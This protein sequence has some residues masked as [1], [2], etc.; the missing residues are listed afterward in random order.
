MKR[1]K[2]LTAALGV[3][4]VAAIALTG[5]D[6]VLNEPKKGT[7]TEVTG[8]GITLVDK[9]VL[10]TVIFDP[11]GGD[12]AVIPKGSKGEITKNI[13]YGER[14]PKPSPDP[15][16][17][18]YTFGGWYT[19]TACKS[20]YD[21]DT[22]VKA[23]FTVYAKWEPISYKVI[24]SL[25]GAPGTP[26]DRLGY[27]TYGQTIT[28]PAAPKWTGHIFIGWFKDA[29]G[30]GTAWNFKTDTVTANITLYAKWTLGAVSVDS[31]TEAIADMDKNAT[32]GEM[33]YTLPGG[34]EEPYTDTITLTARETS[35]ASV[36]IDGSDRFITGNGN[37]ITI[38]SGVT[39]TLKNI[40]FTEI[41]FTVAAG[42]KLI[43]GANDGSA[44]D[45]V[46]EENTGTGITVNGGGTLELNTGAMVIGNQASGIVLEDNSVL[47]MTGGTIINNSATSGGCGVRI[48]GGEFTMNGGTIT[49]NTGTGVTVAAGGKLVLDNGAAVQ[50]NTGTG[51]SVSGGTLEMKAGSSVTG[52]GKSGIY[53]EGTG[54]FTMSGGT[55]SGNNARRGGGVQVNGGT[56]TMS[57]GT[58][59][60]NRAVMNGGGVQ[61]TGGTFTM[62]SG[63]ISGNYAPNGGGVF[64]QGGQNMIFNM[65]GGYIKDNQVEWDGSGVFVQANSTFN[66]TGGEITGNVS[67]RPEYN[68]AGAV[69]LDG[70]TLTGNPRIGNPV[71]SGSGSGW[72]HGNTPA[73]VGP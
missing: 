72:I 44:G 65:S 36:V 16:K 23:D 55:I 3:A 21:F 61:V 6:E 41:P 59:S 12:I 68:T 56:F 64:I 58:I 9:A 24:Y 63:E 35:P 29:A 57:G 22:P 69:Y 1:M 45:V 28:E 47:T 15:T 37:R 33:D 25:N 7:D 71:T 5:C 51:V 54:A 48:D 43:L 34:V 70:G 26:P 52:N 17:A 4:I 62:S 49:G 39:L 53:I 8:Y 14:A 67:L 27:L 32:V 73:D 66:M 19:D 40:T 31:F 18:G 60:G 38:G 10:C 42:G 11:Q 20:L 46:I 13:P 2:F 50:G 30:T